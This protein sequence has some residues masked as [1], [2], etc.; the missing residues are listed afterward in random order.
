MPLG[1]KDKALSIASQPREVVSVAKVIETVVLAHACTHTVY[2]AQ[3]HR[4]PEEAMQGLDSLIKFHLFWN[5]SHI[6][7]YMCSTMYTY[8]HL[9]L[10][11][12]Q[13]YLLTLVF[14][15]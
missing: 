2:T 15:S 13:I 14:P 5:L 7:I 4:I 1:D 3:T 6:F 11:H 12:S 10:L 8:T 9:F